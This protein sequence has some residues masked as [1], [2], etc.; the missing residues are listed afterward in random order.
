MG[1]LLLLFGASCDRSK[2]DRLQGYFE[3]EYVYVASPFAGQLQ[4]LS[5]A[6]GGQTVSGAPLFELEHAAEQAAYDEASRR[7]SQAK[8]TLDDL[9][10][11]KR[12]T[13]ID[14]IRAQLGEAQAAF[15][16]SSKE[17]DRKEKL[18]KNQVISPSDLDQARSLYHQDERRVAELQ[19]ELET[20]SLGARSGQIAAAEQEVRALEA[21]LAGAEWNLSQKKQAAPKAGLVFDTL[22]QEGEWV[23]AGH[24][25]VSLLPPENMKLRMFVPEERLASIHPGEVVRVY[26]DG[27]AKPL[28]GSVSYV[29]PQVEYTPPVI[30][31][32]ENRAKLV[33]LV[34]ARFPPEIAATLH[35]GQP[36]DVAIGE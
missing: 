30:Y 31:S 15:D 33:F 18:L 1:S 26:V 25:V 8:A 36:V 23:P 35:P 5:V 29:S 27:S 7:L 11:G 10:K 19:A 24:P 3:G 16:F 12:P 20:A 34:E 6:R 9:Q 14:A 17:F 22:Y 21:A 13:E 2:S 4:K 28:V 32:R